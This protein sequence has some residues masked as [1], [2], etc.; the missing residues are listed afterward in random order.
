MIN[1]GS[2]KWK[3]RFCTDTCPERVQAEYQSTAIKDFPVDK[4][5]TEVLPKQ[6]DSP[7]SVHRISRFTATCVLVSSVIGTG[8]FTMTGIMA[9]DL[10][11]PWLILLV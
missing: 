7:K 4:N 10:G 2:K 11:D 1:V 6:T 3:S 9:R 8:V 5:V